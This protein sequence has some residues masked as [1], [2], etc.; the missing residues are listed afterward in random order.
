VNQYTIYPNQWAAISG[1]QF[2]NAP[3][4]RWFQNSFIDPP[5]T[6]APRRY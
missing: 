1:P 5:T 6:G 3:I 4:F 2:G